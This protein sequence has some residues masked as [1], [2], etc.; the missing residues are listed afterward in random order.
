MNLNIDHE[1]EP[2]RYLDIEPANEEVKITI[3]DRVILSSRNMCMLS[4][5]PKSNKSTVNLI[6]LMSFLTARSIEGISVKSTGK[7]LYIDTELS[8]LSFF[9]A[10]SRVKK[11]CGVSDSELD[12]N[13]YD[14]FLFRMLSKEQILRNII[15]LLE[16][17][18]EYNY[19]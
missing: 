4:G 11:I 3:N 5:L 18:P 7:A 10:F 2:F 15:S 6:M 13:K 14:I 1:L 9:R 19:T 16:S 12:M 8:N 17:E